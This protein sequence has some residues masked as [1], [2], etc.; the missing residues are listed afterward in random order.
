MAGIS[1]RTAQDELEAHSNSLAFLQ[2]ILSDPKTKDK[3]ADLGKQVSASASLA[4]SVR[5]QAE[6][7]QEIIAQAEEFKADFAAEKA[8]HAKKVKADLDDVAGKKNELT[9]QV[10]AFESDKQKAESANKAILAAAEAQKLAAEKALIDAKNHHATAIQLEKDT[11]Q[12]EEQYK[13]NVAKLEA[14]KADFITAMAQ[15]LAEHNTNVVKL[16]SDRKAVE[17]KKKKLEAALKD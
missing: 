5:K 14:E 3:I 8:A 9:A 7:A 2:S 16:A 13:A 6:D 4:D 11:A 17:D 12:R 10:K 15:K 1:F